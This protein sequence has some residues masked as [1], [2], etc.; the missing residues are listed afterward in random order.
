MGETEYFSPPNK[1]LV[2]S[3]ECFFVLSSKFSRIAMMIFTVCVETERAPAPAEVVYAA[4][5]L[6][7][8]AQQTFL[9]VFRGA[10][11]GTLHGAVFQHGDGG[12]RRRFAIS[13]LK[14]SQN[15]EKYCSLSH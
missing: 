4:S 1:L 11:L 13:Y 8:H 7:R 12:C 2:E 6:A 9:P 15:I 3:R 14:C 10:F 5:H